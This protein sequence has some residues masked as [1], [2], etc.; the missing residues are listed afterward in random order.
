M[1]HNFGGRTGLYGALQNVASWPALTYSQ[2]PNMVGM[3]LTPE[4]IETNVIV[5]DLMME[6]PWRV[7]ANRPHGLLDQL[8]QWVL[9][10]TVRRYG[11]FSAQAS[12]AWSLLQHTV[13]NCSRP[14]EGP[15]RSMIASRPTMTIDPV[16]ALYYDP[17]VVVQALQLL[18]N[19]SAVH[20]FAQ[21]ETFQ[22]DIASITRQMLSNVFMVFFSSMMDAY[23]SKNLTNFQHWSQLLL[24]TILDTD[25]I[26]K[27][28]KMWLVGKWIA[29]AR[30]WGTTPEEVSLY[31]FNAR[32]QLTLWGPSNSALFDYAYKLWGGL[33]HDF[34]YM[35]WELF[36][37]ELGDALAHGRVFDYSAF[38]AQVQDLEYKWSLANNTY[39]EVPEGN[40]VQLAAQML[41]RYA[42]LV[43]ASS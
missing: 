22:H 16:H 38:V 18:V 35:R 2:A 21:Q 43:G 9:N 26:V 15:P 39:P 13:Y 3:G 33:V 14:M 4:A 24:S 5:Y 20:A 41:A 12:A 23:N 17:R 27:T 1:L 32:N 7:Q 37:I 30:A 42:P 31:E 8:D 36:C 34:Y 10:F 25:T 28:Q 40:A 11:G 6:M 29:D 19:A